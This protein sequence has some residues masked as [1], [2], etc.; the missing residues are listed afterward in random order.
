MIEPGRK[1]T[2]KFQRLAPQGAYLSD[3]GV[4]EVLL[5]KKK[6]PEKLKPGDDL[7]VFIYRDSEDRLIA[8]T[9]EPFISV[10]T[11]AVLKVKEVTGIGAFLD[12]GLERDLL[13]PFREQTYKVQ[14]GDGV[15]VTMYVD[16][17]GRLAATQK[18]YDHLSQSSPYKEDDEVE[19]LIYEI[20]RNF[21]A[22]VA[23]DCKYSALIPAKEGVSSLKAGNSVKAR[24][25]K[26]LQDGKLTLTIRKKAYLQ[27]EDDGEAILHYLTTH[28]GRIPFTDKADPQLIADTFDMSKAAFKRAVGHL[29][30]DKKITISEDSITLI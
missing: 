25:V 19:G 3:G 2:L 28:D 6:V 5:P 18:V 17:S 4:E 12:M 11:V 20:S 27:L 26:V 8:T 15:L 29:L 30:K 7:T 16:K 23:V 13:L 9:D 10:G 1:Q 24:V 21:G 14:E 22:F